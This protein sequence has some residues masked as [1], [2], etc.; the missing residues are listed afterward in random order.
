[1]TTSFHLDEHDIPC[2]LYALQQRNLVYNY[3]FE[4]FSNQTLTGVPVQY[5]TPDGWI[6][7]DS[8][9]NGTINYNSN[10]GTCQIVTSSNDGIMVFG[11]SLHEFPRWQQVLPG[12]TVTAKVVLNANTKCTL[13]AQLSDG[14]DASAKQHTGSGDIEI[15]IKLNISSDATGLSF[16][17]TSDS[18][19]VTLQIQ[20]VYANI[21]EV[22][23]E[24][25][26]CMVE[27]IIGERKQYVATET[28]PPTEFSLCTGTESV[29]LTNQYTRLN[30]VLN[31]RFG[32][33]NDGYSLLPN[34]SGYF[35]RAWDNG[36]GTDPD[37]DGRT[38]LGGDVSGDQVGTVEG[39]MFLSHNHKLDFTVTTTPIVGGDKT[40]SS[41]V[42]QSTESTTGDTPEPPEGKETRSKNIAELYTIKWA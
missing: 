23:L 29:E 4:L 42:V 5:G 24:T 21:G 27:G 9:S 15:D 2:Y 1:M 22:A 18:A 34:M 28:A 33:G 37:A 41:V 16:S 3:N 31:G 17:L 7:S 12:T 6:Y 35:S 25:L 8:G 32:T 19:D 36:A 26:P 10:S 30:S 14:K 39:D 20:K 11:Q 40:P 13:V 38:P